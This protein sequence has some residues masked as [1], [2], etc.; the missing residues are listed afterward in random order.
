MQPESIFII[1]FI[2]IDNFLFEEAKWGHMGTT[3]GPNKV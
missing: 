3:L 2:M 1:L